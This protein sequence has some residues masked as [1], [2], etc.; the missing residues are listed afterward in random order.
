MDAH[1][2]RGALVAVAVASL[3][4]NYR[5][6]NFVISAP[7]PAL[8]EQIGRTA[9]QYRRELAIEWLGQEMRTW[10]QPCPI[11][12]HVGEHL[13]AGGATSF[14]FEHGEVFGWRM[15]IQGSQTRILDSVL[16]HEV[17]H[18]IFATHFRQPLPRWADEGACT[19]VEHVSEKSKQQNMLIDFLRTGRGI[20][21]GQMFT[22]KEY[23]HD[24][25]PLYSQGYSV[26]RY[27]VAQGGKKKFLTFLADGLR[28][29]NWTRAINK[30][31]N[32]PNLAA[33][34]SNWLD[35]VR[36]GSPSL[37]TAPA[38]GALVA[39]NAADKD[40]IAS[41]SPDAASRASNANDRVASAK[42]QG[43]AGDQKPGVY[44]MA[45]ANKSLPPRGADDGWHA[46]RAEGSQSDPAKAPDTNATAGP[47]RRAA[48]ESTADLASAQHQ[49][50]RPQDM[51][52]PRQAILEWSRPFQ[53]GDN[54]PGAVVANRSPG[55]AD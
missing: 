10:A 12:A 16:P 34:Q 40:R 48:P 7:T 25:M 31:Y 14:V 27:L 29:E 30:F 1:L 28:D 24:V 43:G 3:G 53:G 11:T 46:P 26:A 13:G 23:P 8:A 15:T 41:A 42:G 55:G 19:T 5:T 35:W 18:T 32:V 20:A 47:D 44:Q 22:M 33:L 36:K 2:L 45:A 17:T 39:V 49:V 21:F 9:E 6:E 51:Q 37:E 38:A 4:A 54:A 50:T 52:R